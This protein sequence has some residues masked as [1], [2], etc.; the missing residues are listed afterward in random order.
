MLASLLKEVND[1]SKDNIQYEYAVCL[2]NRQ[3]LILSYQLNISAVTFC[4]ICLDIPEL[5]VKQFLLKNQHM[6]I[7][8]LLDGEKDNRQRQEFFISYNLYRV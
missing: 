3:V 4:F 7:T 1:L 5:Q 8:G 2:R 6:K